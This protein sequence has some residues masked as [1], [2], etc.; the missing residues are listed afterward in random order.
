MAPFLF[1]NF[2]GTLYFVF[3]L[4]RGASPPVQ[5]RYK[6][7]CSQKIG[8]KKWSC[9]FS[10]KTSRISTPTPPLQ[11]GLLRS[12]STFQNLFL[13][14]LRPPRNLPPPS[15]ICPFSFKQSVLEGMGSSP[16]NLP[17]AA[18]GPY[19]GDMRGPGH[20]NSVLGI[21]GGEAP[22]SV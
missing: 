4:L 16:P 6:M 12:P 7:Q 1:A 17:T 9:N 21:L 8:Q 15:A 13:Q 19:W 22:R 18:T 11:K 14:Q 10:R 3:Y 2:L 20:R 5:V